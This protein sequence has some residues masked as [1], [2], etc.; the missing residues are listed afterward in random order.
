MAANSG[1]LAD[2]TA[3]AHITLTSPH[4][5]RDLFA[6]PGLARKLAAGV[7]APGYRITLTTSNV[8]MAG[9]GATVFFELIGEYGSSGERKGGSGHGVGGS[10]CGGRGNTMP[11]QAHGPTGVE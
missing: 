2:G 6:V 11:L 8:C 4:D 10:G 5:P 1:Q 9:T 7:G 3:T